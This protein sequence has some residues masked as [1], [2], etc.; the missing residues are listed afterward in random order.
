MILVEEIA[1]TSFVLG[2]SDKPLVVDSSSDR[3]SSGSGSGNGS[4]RK[5]R[6]RGIAVWL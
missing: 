4:R 1:S 3:D 5:R 6:S 2:C